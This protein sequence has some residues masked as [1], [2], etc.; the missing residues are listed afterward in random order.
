MLKQIHLEQ[1]AQYC[2]QMGFE[3]LQRR[4]LHSLSGQP[5]PLL[6][7]P[8]GKEVLPHIQVELPVLQFVPDA[9]CPVTGNY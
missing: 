3:C 5:V 1:V 7:H 8:Q 4:R 2:I 6:C 9:P